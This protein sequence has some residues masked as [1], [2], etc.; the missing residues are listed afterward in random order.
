[1]IIYSTK[2]ALT[3]GIELIEKTKENPCAPGWIVYRDRDNCAVAIHPSDWHITLT[4]AT[5]KSERMKQKKIKS[6]TKQLDRLKSLDFSKQPI[7]P[8]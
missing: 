5:E 2:Y 1:M 3:K 6:L 8:A 7:S 4:K